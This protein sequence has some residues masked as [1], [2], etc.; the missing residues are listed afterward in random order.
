MIYH[1]N[2]FCSCYWC[3]GVACSNEWAG[4]LSEQPYLIKLG[5]YNYCEGFQTY[6]SMITYQITRLFLQGLGMH[7]GTRIFHHIKRNS[8]KKVQS[9]N[10]GKVLI[11]KQIS[12]NLSWLCITAFW[13]KFKETQQCGKPWSQR[14]SKKH[15]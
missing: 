9:D 15:S 6:N 2:N 14:G 13:G 10:N 1:A 8:N 5:I 3:S 11:W 4:L 7:N 12:N